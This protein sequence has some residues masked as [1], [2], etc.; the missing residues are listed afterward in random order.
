MG[1]LISD[2]LPHHNRQLSIKILR[3]NIFTILNFMDKGGDF[4]KKS[5]ILKK[6]AYLCC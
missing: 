3:S 5:C 4:W 6:I 2:L 1:M